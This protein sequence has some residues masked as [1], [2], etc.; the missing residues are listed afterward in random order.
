MKP[1]VCFVFVGDHGRS[2]GFLGF[3]GLRLL[4]VE[5]A[6]IPGVEGVGLLSQESVESGSGGSA[7][8]GTGA[9]G[10]FELGSPF[11]FQ[12]G[13]WLGMCP[14]GVHRNVRKLANS[15]GG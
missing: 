15:F 2:I 5:A 7:G 9:I 13:C 11:L 4:G 3:S 14:N 6:S 10:A 1:A 8:L 12:Q